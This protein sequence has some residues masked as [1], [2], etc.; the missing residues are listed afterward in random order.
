MLHSQREIENIFHQSQWMYKYETRINLNKKLI[1]T[2]RFESE[3]QIEIIM[4]MLYGKRIHFQY[5]I[6]FP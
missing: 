2:L 3:T 1:G 4:F 5:L 6:L